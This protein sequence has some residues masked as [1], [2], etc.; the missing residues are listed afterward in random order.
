MKKST[1]LWNAQKRLFV[2]DVQNLR[3]NTIGGMARGQGSR[4]VPE[5]AAGMNQKVFI[6][7]VAG[8]L[9]NG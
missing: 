2:G 8:M 4:I 5:S 3:V 7:K 9:R 1:K 6:L